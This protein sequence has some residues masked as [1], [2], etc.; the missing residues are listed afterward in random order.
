MWLPLQQPSRRAAREQALTSTAWRFLRA[1]R[2]FRAFRVGLFD[3]VQCEKGPEPG[4]TAGWQEPPGSRMI[5]GV[6]FRWRDSICLGSTPRLHAVRP[7]SLTLAVTVPAQALP[8]SSKLRSRPATPRSIRRRRTTDEL[9]S[10]GVPAESIAS[11]FD[12]FYQTRRQ[13]SP[14]GMR[15][16]SRTFPEA[17][18][19]GQPHVRSP[20]PSVE[21]LASSEPAPD[22]EIPIPGEFVDGST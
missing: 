9:P 2:A 12:R 22:Y 5:R 11:E 14:S 19:L 6:P 16:Q 3:A 13:N 17:D 10:A 1:F 8:N 4:Q 18:S 21:A 15:R 7:T 20:A